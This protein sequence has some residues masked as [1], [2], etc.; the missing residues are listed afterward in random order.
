MR[1]LPAT[2][3]ALSSPAY[4]R[5]IPAQ[6]IG[7]TG[8][9]MQ[10]IAQDW[11]VLELTGSAAAVGLVVAM[12][13]L[14]MLLL[15]LW[16]GVLVDRFPI[17]RLLVLTQSIAAALALLL[18]GL[19]LAGVVQVWHVYAIAL[20]LGLVVVVDGPARQ[21]FVSELV[22]SSQV[23]NAVGL[24]STV[25]QFSGVLGPAV[26]GVLVAV[27][28]N[29]WAFMINGLAC[30]AVAAIVFTVRPQFTRP[31]VP[32]APG[33]LRQGLRYIMSTSEV[34]WAILLVALAGLMAFNLPVL[35][36]TMAD[37][38]FH[39]GVS[40]YSLLTTV[41]AVGALVG[42]LWA[43]SR[44]TTSRLRSLTG[45]LGALGVLYAT[46]AVVPGQ[47]AFTA[48]LVLSGVATMS[49]LIGANSL[50]QL[51]TA[52]EVRGRVMSVYMMV[53]LGGQSIAGPLVG[54][55]SDWLGPRAALVL[56]GVV[57]LLVTA[58]LAA[59]MARQAHLRLALQR[60]RWAPRLSIVRV[61]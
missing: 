6:F 35:L 39:T 54:R 8:V 4:R 61:P 2:F 24:N 47:W 57:L 41:N 10:R 32:R 58:V 34:F 38:E 33:A 37:S 18:G 44:T 30:T 20:A 5:F 59:L 56:C 19:S 15:G 49:F 40:G 25:F 31:V 1:R 51:S 23:R 45:G 36:A 26:S 17:R 52:P 48:L 11:L 22:P 29:G 28:G 14:P 9:W 53:L 46:M 50:I 42:G 7:S 3:S 55:F 13:F 43:G 27:V 21:A 12:Q 16:G 60:E